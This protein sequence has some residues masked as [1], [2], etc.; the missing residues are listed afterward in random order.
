MEAIRTEHDTQNRTIQGQKMALDSIVVELGSLRFLGKD[1]DNISHMPSPMMTPAVESSMDFVEGN[2]GG[3]IAELG[4]SA[5]V[6]VIDH[7]AGEMG[8]IDD[9]VDGQAEKAS[10][11]DV[12]LSTLNPAA[13]PF[14]PNSK[15]DEDDDIEMGEVAEDPK[16]VKGKRKIREELEEGEASDS[17]SALSDPPDD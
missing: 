10:S 17:S 5:H 15:A 3:V 12:P 1:R 7:G 9:K 14:Y 2:P 6:S 4:S 11:D 13:K 16:N 8:E